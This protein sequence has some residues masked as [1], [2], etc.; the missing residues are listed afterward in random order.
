MRSMELYYSDLNDDA[1][2]AFDKVF[3]PP[4]EFNHETMPLTIYEVEDENEHD[5]RDKN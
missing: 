2:K 1:K 4:E 3:G 5:S